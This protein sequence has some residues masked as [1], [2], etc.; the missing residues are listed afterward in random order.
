MPSTTIGELLA[1]ACQRHQDRPAIIRGTEVLT[2]GQLL[3]RASQLSNAMSGAGLRPGDRVAAMLEDRVQSI[4]VYVACALGGFAVIHVNDR[5]APPE[6]EHIVT[7]ATVRGFFHTDGRSDVVSRVSGLDELAVFA[8]IGSNRAPGATDYEALLGTGR[9]ELVLAER[10]PEDLA[11]VGYTSGTTGFPKG[12]MVSQAALT[13]CVKLL[14]TMY[15][16]SPY[17]RCAFTGT[18]SFVSGIWGV[19]Y[20]HLYMGGAT[21]FLHPYTPESWVEHIAKDR[22]TFTYAPSPLVPGFIDEVR[23]RPDA[24]DS[25]ESVLHSASPLPADLVRE[26][27]DLIGER[28]VEVWGM[29]EGVAPFSATVRGDWRGESVASDVFASSGRAFPSARI[30]SVD[31]DG[32]E[33]GPDEEGELVVESEI[34]FS[35]YLDDPQKTAEVITPLGFATGDL[36]RIDPEGYVYVLGRKK[37]L[38]ITGGMNVYPA[39]IEAAL[40]TYPEVLECSV[41]ALPDQK[42]GE[43]VAAAIVLRPGSLAREDDVIDHLRSRVAGYKK[44]TRVFLV[45]SLPRNASLKVLKPELIARFTESGN[46][47]GAERNNTIF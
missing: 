30:R 4:E 39:E 15:R 7:N 20:P 37:E 17:G 31:L 26:L 11:I 34:L 10:R 40:L 32:R 5:L 6:V 13:A 28:Y 27:V 35:G 8:T 25:L 38:I 44:P 3:D 16:I 46:E 43:A 14:P 42:W 45:E 41:F 36:G 29:T 18:L 19:I 1:F 24:L 2:Y 47:S 12:A 21:T 9:R 22:S 33:L 23:R